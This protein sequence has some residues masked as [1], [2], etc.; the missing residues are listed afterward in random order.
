[1][2]LGWGSHLWGGTTAW[3]LS[4]PMQGRDKAG[5]D[6]LEKKLE[7]EVRYLYW[8]TSDRKSKRQEALLS[9][10]TSQ[11]PLAPPTDRSQ[12]ETAVKGIWE[13]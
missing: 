13:M 12:Q 4:V 1:M 9:L 6:S 10:P 11:L 5:S 7:A 2:P 8:G 3:L